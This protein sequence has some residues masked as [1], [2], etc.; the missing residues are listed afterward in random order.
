MGSIPIACPVFFMLLQNEYARFAAG[1]YG[2]L[3]PYGSLNL[4]YV[5]AS[6]EEHTEAALSDTTADGERKFARKKCLV[7]WE[8]AAV[9]TACEFEL[10]IEAFR[11]N[12]DAHAGDF[13]RLA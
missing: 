7:E 10:L 9:I 11:R 8:L 1:L 12:S 3:V 2:F 13:E 5:R 6:E 4:A